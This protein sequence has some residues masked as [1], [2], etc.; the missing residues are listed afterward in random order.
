[1]THHD[2]SAAT[3]AP[4][5]PSTNTASSATPGASTNN[6]AA[7]VFSMGYQLIDPS[8]PT[9]V[10]TA[11]LARLVTTD[12]I[13]AGIKEVLRAHFAGFYTEVEAREIVAGVLIYG[14]VL[15]EV[16][17]GAQVSPHLIDEIREGVVDNLIVK[18]LTEGSATFDLSIQL[19]TS[20][21]GW[22]R[23]HANNQVM[24]QIRDVKR[25]V[26]RNGTPI[27]PAKL[28]EVVPNADVVYDDHDAL[29]DGDEKQR[30][31]EQFAV[32]RHGLRGK[33]R[34]R[35]TVEQSSE[36]FAIPLA[37]RP[38][39]YKDRDQMAKILAGNKNLA[40]RSLETFAAIVYGL[41]DDPDVVNRDIDERFMSLWDDYSEAD[42]EALLAQSSMFAHAFARYAVETLVRPPKKAINRMRTVAGKLATGREWRQLAWA[43]V[44]SWVDTE[45]DPVSEFS[46]ATVEQQ[47][48]S[49]KGYVVSRS[50]WDEF[51]SRAARHP[52]APLGDSIEK[53]QDS[54][55]ALAIDHL[56]TRDFQRLKGETVETVAAEPA[57]AELVGA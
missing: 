51:V 6:T 54:L 39:Y 46:V 25:S 32:E 44:E 2:A 13:D 11:A 29:F 45:C 56:P 22:V 30:L 18:I 31:C 24:Q 9:G 36:M 57:A 49:R 41:G 43:L 33:P 55:L 20:A 3:P 34:T 27:E 7:S 15:E 16:V 28:T 23:K 38:A 17:R 1:M 21:S 19:T 47:D 40:Y 50:R 10:T 53:V 26:R 52:G 35:T 5:A 4:T 37:V 8:A 12:E 42:A 48:N 14:R